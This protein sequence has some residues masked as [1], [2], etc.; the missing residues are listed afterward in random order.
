MA[1][2]GPRV[3]AYHVRLFPD[4]VAKIKAIAAQ[5]RI[6]WQ[7]ELRTLVHRALNVEIVNPNRSES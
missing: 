3:K 5:K 6:R 7:I 2:K 4:D 1:T